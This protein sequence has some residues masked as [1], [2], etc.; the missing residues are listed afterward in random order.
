MKKENPRKTQRKKLK[1]P[2]QKLVKL[3]KN[4]A[5]KSKTE[6]K[7]MKSYGKRERARPLYR[8]AHTRR[9]IGVVYN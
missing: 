9:S 2:G 8:S 7:V 6:Q 3:S 1:T 4:E 5:R